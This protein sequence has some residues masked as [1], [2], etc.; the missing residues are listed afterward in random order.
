M[1]LHTQQRLLWDT[2]TG[3][4]DTE[5]VAVAFHGSTRFPAAAGLRLYRAMYR[6]RIGEVLEGTFPLVAQR[7]GAQEFRRL[8][9]QYLDV[10]PS[11]DARI[12]FVGRH[13]A[14]FL[15]A[16]GD[17][18]Q[19]STVNLAQLEWA[20]HSAQLAAD[21]TGSARLSDFGPD[22]FTEARFELIPSL[23]VVE[24]ESGVDCV[25]WCDRQQLFECTVRNDEALALRRAQ[26]GQGTPEICAAFVD[27]EDPIQRAWSVLGAW[28]SR[29]W[30]MRILI[31]EGNTT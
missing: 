24:T 17:D 19:R 2:V 12:E 6:A 21:P 26:E 8:A 9:M 14:G 20:R 27:S 4:T 15:R 18:A 22:R 31:A 5:R 30:I 1:S 25:I 3:W 10:H 23:S 16:T 7:L 28:S 11:S 29:R 13:F